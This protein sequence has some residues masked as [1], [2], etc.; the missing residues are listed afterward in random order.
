MNK[1]NLERLEAE[2]EKK[3]AKKVKRKKQT[4]KVNSSSVKKLANIIYKK[5]RR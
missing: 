2:I 1:Q 4:M 3:Y 5:S